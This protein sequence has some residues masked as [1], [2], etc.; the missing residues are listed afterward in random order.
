MASAVFG[1]SLLGII[2]YFPPRYITAM[3]AGQALAGI[4]AALAEIFSLWL[5]ASPVVSALL[6]FSIGDLMLFCSLLSYIFLQK[7]VRIV[8]S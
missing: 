2:G 5:G 1:G 7:A 4:F 3:S 8:F 6:Y